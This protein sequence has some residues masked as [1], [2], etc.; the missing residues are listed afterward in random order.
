MSCNFSLFIRS[1]FQFLQDKIKVPPAENKSSTRTKQKFHQ[2]DTKVSSR[3]NSW[4][5]CIMP[6]ICPFDAGKL[7]GRR[8]AVHK[9][10]DEESRKEYLMDRFLW[11]S[12][13]FADV[14]FYI[15]TQWMWN[16]SSAFPFARCC[17]SFF[18]SRQVCG[19]PT[20]LRCRRQRLFWPQVL[21]KPLYW[22]RMHR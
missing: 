2:H 16:I 10:I 22:W 6:V 5:V 11:K 18:F 20:I 21:K 7:S 4:I 12:N 13:I 8:S 17:W 14:I 1:L 3:R 15:L 9:S 19:L